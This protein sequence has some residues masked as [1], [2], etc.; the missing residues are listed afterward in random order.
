MH[1]LR[2]KVI[3]DLYSG[4][5]TGQE[6]LKSKAVKHCKDVEQSVKGCQANV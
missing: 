1:I 5:T 4:R 3:S 6:T 2:P